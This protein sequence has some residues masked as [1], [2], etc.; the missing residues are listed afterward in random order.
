M[1]QGNF[2]IL[3]IFLCLAACSSNKVDFD[4][5]NE[6][7][8][9]IREVKIQESDDNLSQPEIILEPYD[10]FRYSVKIKSKTDGDY[11][12]SYNQEGIIKTLK[13][14]Y[15]TNG[16]PLANYTIRINSDS[17]RIEEKPTHY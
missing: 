15:F 9:K 16:N 8:K 3:F 11:F 12:L 2:I 14:G 6:T 5:I 17:L 4:L 7:G 1:R 13:F 10:N